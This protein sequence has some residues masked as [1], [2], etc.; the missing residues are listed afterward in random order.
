MRTK[1]TSRKSILFGKTV[2]YLLSLLIVTL[3]FT[4][5]D[6]IEE[7]FN[8]DENE[9]PVASFTYTKNSDV[10]PDIVDFDATSSSDS[11]GS[12]SDFAWDFGDGETGAGDMASHYYA[13]AGPFTV[14]LTV[15]DDLGATGSTTDTVTFAE[16]IQWRFEA[17]SPVY[18][19]SPAV[20]ADGTIYFGTGIFM[21]TDAGSLYAL[22]P[23]GTEMW[24][25]ELDLYP[26]LGLHQGDNG[27]SPTIG[28]DGTIYIQGA[29]SALYA[30]DSQ[31]TRLWKYEAYDNYPNWSDVGQRTPAIG[32]DGILYVSADALYALYPNGTRKWRFIAD[33]GCRASPAIGP[34]GTI[35]V[36]GGQDNLFAV[37]PD[38]SNRWLFML[39]FADQMSFASPAVDTDGTIYIAAEDHDTGF[40]YAVNP[41]GTKKWCYT[42][43]GNYRVLRSSPAIAPDGTIYVGTKSGGPGTPAQMLAF[44]PDGTLKWAF[45]VPQVT[46]TADDIYSSPTVGADGMIYFGAETGSLYAVYPDGTL[47]WSVPL[48]GG[49][50]WSSP[51]L[52][53][54]GTLYIGS[55]QTTWEGVWLGHL[56]AIR[57]TS[58]GLAVSPWPKFRKNNR[59]TGRF[60][61]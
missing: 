34:D 59:N 57:T 14:T 6:L 12:V 45:D 58:P 55:H 21:H 2:F 35:Y 47:K 5:C 41:N 33:W 61:D 17:D 24:K 43:P 54:D 36:M 32:L 18:Y 30:Y 40:L 25:R 31:G 38:G 19:S 20:A 13:T 11:D 23:D 15:T 48:Y 50:N 3:L 16:G 26:T 1:H 60:G 42:V 7:L 44:Y 37:N 51:A 22:N 27:C 4:S 9:N 39:D 56:F 53:N 46:Q 52:L 10:A 8:G 28:T 49:N 29:T